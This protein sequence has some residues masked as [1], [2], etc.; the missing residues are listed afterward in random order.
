MGFVANE[1][2]APKG[3]STPFTQQPA[4]KSNTLGFIPTLQ[5]LSQLKLIGKQPKLFA[6]YAV[7]CGW[8]DSCLCTK[9]P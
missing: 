6:Q 9:P 5:P 7:A 3:R 1:Q 8:T 4:A 2:M